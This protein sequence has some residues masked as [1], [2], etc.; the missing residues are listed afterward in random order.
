MQHVL[1]ALDKISALLGQIAALHPMGGMHGGRLQAIAA[2]IAA[3]RDE[4]A[5]AQHTHAGGKRFTAEDAALDP[6]ESGPDHGAHKRRGR[7]RKGTHH[8]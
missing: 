6:I 1:N 2:D 5:A 3:A 8:A 4:H 7:A